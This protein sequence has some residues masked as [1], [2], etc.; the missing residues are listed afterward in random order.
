VCFEARDEAY[1]CSRA[2]IKDSRQ[3][4]RSV[5]G[6]RRVRALGSFE[7]L[8]SAVRESAETKI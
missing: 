5:C 7:K 8:L 4:Q 3:Q 1:A 6:H 2:E